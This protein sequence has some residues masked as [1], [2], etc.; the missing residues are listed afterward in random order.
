MH[1][2]WPVAAGALVGGALA[3]GY[4]KRRRNARSKNAS[5]GQ[6]GHANYQEASDYLVV[7][8]DPAEAPTDAAPRGLALTMVA[9]APP[10]VVPAERE[11]RLASPAD[12]WP[13]AAF[14]TPSS[15]SGTKPG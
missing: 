13:S 7:D 9:E 1:S 5:A 2:S 14:T 4:L 12:R 10:V 6:L 8:F 15:I 3:V 11:P